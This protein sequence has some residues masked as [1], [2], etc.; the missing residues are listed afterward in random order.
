MVQ[1]II[2]VSD[3][4]KSKDFY[5][6][7]LNLVPSL[8]VPGMTEFTLEDN[9]K[10][11]IMPEKGIA[12]ILGDKTPHPSKANGIPRCEIYLHVSSVEEYYLRALKEGAKEVS[13]PKQRDWGD[14]VGYVA[15]PDGHIVA[16][17]GI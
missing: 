17:A 11:G 8:D 5:S 3:Q 7:V 12:K 1:F 9:C 4:L 6:K 14:T 15:D 13:S 10:L 2:Y 16:F